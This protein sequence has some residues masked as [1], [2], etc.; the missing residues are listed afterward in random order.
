MPAPSFELW[1]L[2]TGNMV[3]AF[4]TEGAA[5]AAVR[6]ALDQHG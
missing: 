1:D 2:Q 3:D 5:L 6:D 4:N